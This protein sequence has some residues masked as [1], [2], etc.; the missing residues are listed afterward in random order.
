MDRER[1][2]ENHVGSWEK[3]CSGACIKALFSLPHSGISAP[4]I[5]YDDDSLLKYIHE[6][7]GFARQSLTNI[8]RMCLI[9]IMHVIQETVFLEVGE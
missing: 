2:C 7:F 3:Q 6:S 1:L 4:G 5:P 8:L 9:I